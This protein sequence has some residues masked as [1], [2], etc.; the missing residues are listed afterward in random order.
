MERFVFVVAVVIA[1]FFGLGA[2]FGN[3]VN[4]DVDG[5]DHEPEAILDVGAGQLAPQTYEGRTLRIRHI[6]ARVVITPEDRDDFSIEINNP[7]G[8]PMPQVSSEDGRVT[9]DGRLRGR[10]AACSGGGADVRGYERAT[11]ETMPVVTVHAPRDLVLERS[12]AGTTDIGALSSLE[13]DVSDCGA[14]AVGDVA[15]KL[16]VDVAGSGTVSA[17][18]VRMLNADLSGSGSVSVG[19]VSESADVDMAGSGQ[20]AIEALTGSL[21]SDG[22]G[23]GG[24]TIGGGAI[25]DANVDLAGSGGARIGASIESLEVSIVGSGSVVVSN[26]VGDVDADI[27]GSGSVTARAITGR[28][29]REILGSGEVRVGE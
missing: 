26:T 20:V 29:H 13:L 4:F 10:V 24:L 16:D 22:A 19:A 2:F 18:A 21:T 3:F 25:T 28:I 1:V 6:A 11:A 27:A 7:G 14:V 12:G 8:L 9:I 17:G 15:N 23:S 5:W